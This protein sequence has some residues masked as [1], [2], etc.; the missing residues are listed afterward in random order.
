[1]TENMTENDTILDELDTSGVKPTSHS[2]N[3]KNVFF[4]DS[5]TIRLLKY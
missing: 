5:N 4:K 2:T 1:M 3:L